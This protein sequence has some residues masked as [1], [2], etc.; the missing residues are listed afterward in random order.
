MSLNKDYAEQQA[1][2]VKQLVEKGVYD[3]ATYHT[4]FGHDAVTL[5]EGVT[6][7]SIATHVEF[8][9]NTASA[10]EVANAELTRLA[11]AQNEKMTAGT[12]TFAM[13]GLTINS[14][15]RLRQQVG[16]LGENE[17]WEYGRSTTA[18]DY[19]HSD[20]ATTWLTDQREAQI[21]QATALFS[22]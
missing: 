17:A 10:V 20:V 2:A 4:V 7:E 1:A 8:I 6:P 21:A 5:P 13:G 15:H 11:H 14:E 18:V 16:T 22:K 12:A 19:V 3:K 9:N